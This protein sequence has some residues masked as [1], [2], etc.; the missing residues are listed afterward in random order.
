MIYQLAKCYNIDLKRSIV[1]G[2]KERD[3]ISGLVAGCQ[4]ALIKKSATNSLDKNRK[5]LEFY[6]LLDFAKSI[7]QIRD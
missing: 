7:K 2:D 6:S 3:G 4:G 5:L 1:V